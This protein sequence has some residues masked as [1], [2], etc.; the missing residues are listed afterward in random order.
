M[1]K[2]LPLGGLGESGMGF[3]HGRA[4]FDAFTHR[5]SVLRRDLGMDVKMRYPPARIPL[6]RLKRALRWF[7]NA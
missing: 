6:D 7:G 5:R 2:H 1:G 4:S 3:C